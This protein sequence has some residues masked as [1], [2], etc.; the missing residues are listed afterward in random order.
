MNTIRNS[1]CINFGRWKRTFNRW[2]LFETNL[3]QVEMEK[4]FKKN[5]DNNNTRLS[6]TKAIEKP[7]RNFS[8]LPSYYQAKKQFLL[9]QH[10]TTTMYHD[11]KFQQLQLHFLI[12]MHKKNVNQHLSCILLSDRLTKD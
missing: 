3:H 10:T 7:K 6:V 4:I 5:C 9:K 1:K 2:K 8:L 12:Q 11:I